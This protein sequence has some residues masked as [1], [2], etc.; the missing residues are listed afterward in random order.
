[1]IGQA[2]QAIREADAAFTQQSNF[3][4]AWR[5][6]AGYC[7][8]RT[9]DGIG[10]TISQ[11]SPYKPDPAKMNTEAQQALLTLVT[12][13]ASWIT[14]AGQEW[15]QWSPAPEV[16]VDP[17]R[18]WL[19]DCT[20]RALPHLEASGF[21]A[22]AMET[23]LAAGSVGVA[24][25]M[26]EGAKRGSPAALSFRALDIGSYAIAENA[27]SVVDRLYWKFSRTVAQAIEEWGAER[28]PSNLTE[29]DRDKQLTQREEFLLVVRP[30]AERKARI[31]PL[32]M[33][34]EV[35]VIHQTSRSLVWEGGSWENP[36]KVYRWLTTAESRPWGV[37]PGMMALADA[38][39]VNYL[40]LLG[41]Y[42][43]EKL[44]DPPV[45]AMDNVTGAL[46]LRSGG[47]TVV[48]DLSQAPR[49]ISEVGDVR[50]LDAIQDRKLRQLREYFHNT[51]FEAF[52]REDK[53]MT[54]TESRLR[55]GEKLDRYGPA[56]HRL[57]TEWVGPVLERVF[58]ILMRDG[59]F[60]PPPR[61]AFVDTQQG[62]QFLYPKVVQQGRMALAM[63]AL[64]SN[65]IRELLA[66]VL[67]I[68]QINPEILDH[69]DFDKALRIMGQASAF[70][71]QAIRSVD[72]VAAV[73]AARQQQQLAMQAAQ[74]A[75]QTAAQPE[76]GMNAPAA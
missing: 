52:L 70:T 38:K 75:M 40:D 30:R 7:L 39:G 2:N 41:I 33:P 12:G 28:L 25:S 66:E 48:S 42:A 44:I 57:S 61:E 26:V 6:A 76:G 20:R 22:H 13:M 71:D 37:G 23:F 8:P 17:V 56:F 15:F 64:A 63:N 1:M 47:V 18:R 67:P 19:L 16:D 4:S 24:C 69:I 5:E 72:E 29:L 68:A 58:M 3:M 51:L 43:A 27:A 34:F 9:A 10:V 59:Y 53:A 32:A 50:F 35:L 74:L 11:P 55:Q 21:Y 31:G 54:A 36:A 46:D 73:R 14:P 62:P 49:P 65:G 45:A 60:A